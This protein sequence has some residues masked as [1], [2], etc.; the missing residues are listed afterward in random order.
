MP[1][2]AVTVTATFGAIPL[3]TVTYNGNGNDGGSAPTD[4]NSPYESG[5]AVTVLGYGDLSRSDHYFSGWS[6]QNS[7]GGQFGGTGGETF[8]ITE[9]TTFSAIWTPNNITSYKVTVSGG[10]GGRW[11]QVNETVTVT[12]DNRVGFTFQNWT[13]DPA[14][15]F[16]GTNT[17]TATF[18]MPSENVTVT[19]NFAATYY[20]LTTKVLPDGSG[21]VSLDP[22]QPDE[23][24]AAN[25]SVRATAEAFSGWT[26]TGW[27]G[28]T[29]TTPIIN[30]MMDGNKTLTAN[31]VPTTTQQTQHYRLT[32][33]VSPE[34]S[35]YVSL[36]PSQPDN[37]YEA[38]AI[39]A[40]EAVAASGW[41][42]TGWSG[43]STSTTPTINIWM[44]E[45]N[46]L[47][48]NFR[49]TILLDWDGI[50]DDFN[51]GDNVNALGGKWYFYTHTFAHRPA[52]NPTGCDRK[53]YTSALVDEK[54]EWVDN[55]QVDENLLLFTGSYGSNDVT[56]PAHGGQFS[57][58]MKFSNLRSP[59]SSVST[60]RSP[61][62]YPGV[63]M[64]TM[65]TEDPYGIGVAF[66]SA[67]AIKFWM[68]AS[69]AD[70]VVK[71][72]IEFATQ[73]AGIGNNWECNADAS[74]E[75]VLLEP[76]NSWKEYTIDIKA[77]N[78]GS[79]A[80]CEAPKLCRPTWETGKPY[81]Y[82]LSKA[83]KIAWFIE[84]VSN[85]SA[86]GATGW[87]AVDD[88]E[89]VGYTPPR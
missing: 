37:G 66:A 46:T 79:G 61:D 5:A 57:G 21:S 19:A 43:V 84:G 69:S 44:N 25:R 48:A 76:S 87:I 83:S 24:Y 35:G 73:I 68:K 89:I 39:V 54:L 13:S 16:N 36:N 20:R 33:N 40:A 85:G 65:L 80:A 47:T 63:G 11:Y 29:S 34:G 51:D 59:W 9:H 49:R 56:A 50:L 60:D 64:G 55:A 41:T 53:D 45:N 72:K 23:G 2:R 78:S 6:T 26:F 18:I 22:H 74:Y 28:E 12:A 82:D 8:T 27:S 38:D 88:I 67:T 31:F 62:V 30:I 1:P 58:V 3:Y 75:V 81:T 10:S 86:S 15:A 7:G 52:A 77:S 71:F 32:T 4:L 14:V 42:F 17:P 70:L